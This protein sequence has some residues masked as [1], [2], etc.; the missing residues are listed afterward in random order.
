[1]LLWSNKSNGSVGV[2]G[3]DKL[4]LG[5]EADGKLVAWKRVDGER[6]WNTE[7]LLHRGLSAPVLFGK[8]VAVGDSVGLLHLLSRDNGVT[9]NRLSTDGSAIAV[10]PVA[11]GKT[12]VVVTSAGAIYGFVPE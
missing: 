10:A 12:L 8:A 9:L 7:Q 6:A 4:L 11:V 5:T 2:S 1:Q 3:D